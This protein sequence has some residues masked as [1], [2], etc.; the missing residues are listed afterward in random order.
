MDEYDREFTRMKEESLKSKQSK[1]LEELEQAR[2]AVEDCKRA[3]SD[4]RK[5]VI[6][7]C[8]KC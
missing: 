2:H 3:L 7:S 1:L 6:F 8:F 4:K 5:Q